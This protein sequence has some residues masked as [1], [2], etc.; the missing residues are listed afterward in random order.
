MPPALR[1]PSLYLNRE[2]SQIAFNARV[3][4][5]AKDPD[6]P[7]LERLRFLGISCSNLD[8]FFEVRVASLKQ[9]T[10]FGA[11]TPGADGLTPRAALAA[12]RERTIALVNDQYHTF[13][14]ILV[15]RKS[16]RSELQSQR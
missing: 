8:E 11:D 15:D 1:D 9:L 13:S 5:Q 14:E 3:L 6:T 10:Q 12:I 2:L 16:T 4:E 7:L